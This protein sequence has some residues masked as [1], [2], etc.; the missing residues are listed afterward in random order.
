MQSGVAAVILDAA[1][2]LGKK[3]L[4]ENV[5]IHALIMAAAFAATF[6]FRINVIWIILASAII[7]LILAFRHGKEE[8]S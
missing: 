5:W 1:C 7:G 8:K 6:F 4:S 3:A 2:S